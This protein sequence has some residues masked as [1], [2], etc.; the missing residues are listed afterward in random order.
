MAQYVYSSPFRRAALDV[1]REAGRWVRVAVV[2]ERPRE[3]MLVRDFDHF[4]VDPSAAD[5]AQQLAFYDAV[6]CGFADL[7]LIGG[8][9]CGAIKA[10][11]LNGPPGSLD[12]EGLEAIGEICDRLQLELTSHQSDTRDFGRS[13]EV[14]FLLARRA[15]RLLDDPYDALKLALLLEAHSLQ[16][17]ALG[18]LRRYNVGVEAA[19]NIDEALID[20][21]YEVEP[22]ACGDHTRAKVN[23]PANELLPRQRRHTARRLT[24]HCDLLHYPDG[25]H[26]LGRLAQGLALPEQAEI[27]VR[28]P[29][30]T[31]P[32]FMS[33]L[34]DVI[35][36][37]GVAIKVFQDPAPSGAAN[38]CAGGFL[39]ATGPE[40][41]LAVYFSG[42]REPG[43]PGWDYD[44]LRAA[45]M[46]EGKVFALR[47]GDHKTRYYAAPE[48]AEIAPELVPAVSR[49]WLDAC[50]AWSVPGVSAGVFQALVAFYFGRAD[51]MNKH[52]LLRLYPVV[53]LPMVEVRGSETART[54]LPQRRLRRSTVPPGAEEKAI[55]IALR[56][57]AIE[58]CNG[59]NLREPHFTYEPQQRMLALRQS[60]QPQVV[61]SWS[62]KLDRTRL[63]L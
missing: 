41:E 7:P 39:T 11:S 18:L 25:E 38:P 45:A 31:L 37:S 44:L 21:T 59:E 56:L 46:S 4:P 43:V 36:Q 53:T 33:R 54:A 26:R 61:R 63:P 32:T 29:G 1:L 8:G 15:D 60:G 9:A 55:E 51:W 47:T 62:A 19:H 35:A 6:F 57:H 10:I 27:V 58:W 3:L 14:T 30:P 24:I 20:L 5:A 2:G 40:A 52:R 23:A 22:F 28:L 42:E 48:D 34:T 12:A 49:A 16:Q 17:M 13:K 50:G